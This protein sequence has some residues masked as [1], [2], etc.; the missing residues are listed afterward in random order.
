MESITGSWAQPMSRSTGAL[1]VA[2]DHF[3]AS[4]LGSEDAEGEGSFKPALILY[5]HIVY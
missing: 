4:W 1:H 3:D 2:R 5:N